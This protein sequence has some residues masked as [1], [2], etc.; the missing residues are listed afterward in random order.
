MHT[1]NM[2]YSATF[3]N[4]TWTSTFLVLYMVKPCVAKSLASL[5]LSEKLMQCSYHYCFLSC[6]FLLFL[7]TNYY[8]NSCLHLTV[9]KLAFRILTLFLTLFTIGCLLL[10]TICSFVIHLGFQI[11][12]WMHRLVWWGGLSVSRNMRAMLSGGLT[13]L[14]VWTP[15]IVGLLPGHPRQNGQSWNIRLSCISS[16]ISKREFIVSVAM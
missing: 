2:I 7:F 6:W 1:C 15:S 13:L 12:S 16:Q 3:W 5:C 4:P 10:L 14:Q 8:N 11:P 9:A